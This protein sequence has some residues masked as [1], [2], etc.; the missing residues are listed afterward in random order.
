LPVL[1]TACSSTLRR[2]CLLDHLTKSPR[3]SCLPKHEQQQQQ[4]LRRPTVIGGAVQSISGNGHSSLALGSY[5]VSLLA[6]SLPGVR[7]FPFHVNKPSLPS[8]SAEEWAMLLQQPQQQQ[9]QPGHSRGSVPE[10]QAFQEVAT[11]DCASYNSAV[12]FSTPHFLETQEFLQRLGNILPG[13]PVRAH[14][15][16]SKG[17]QQGVAAKWPPA[18]KP[19]AF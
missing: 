9:Q 7:L 16:S 4:H 15:S 1:C 5:G 13:M 3:Q 18:M 8:F 14:N 17:L 2:Q 19:A 6:A 11:A 12:V 10:G